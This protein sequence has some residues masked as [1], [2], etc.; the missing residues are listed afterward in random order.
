MFFQV[1]VM[2]FTLGKWETYLPQIQVYLG[3]HRV[4]QCFIFRVFFLGRQQASRI[5]KNA[6]GVECQNSPFSP[7]DKGMT[8]T[9][10][11]QSISIQF[12]TEHVSDQKSEEKSMG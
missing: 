12:E 8:I 10:D 6:T 5:E 7:Q 1:I 3:E 11:H 9:W 2:D 4:A